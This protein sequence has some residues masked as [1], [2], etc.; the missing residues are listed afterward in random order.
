[1]GI[2]IL[3]L[4]S[5]YRNFLPGLGVK[6]AVDENGYLCPKEFHQQLLADVKN[7]CEPAL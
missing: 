3:V 4:M 7:A 1:M 6:I 2:L 5:S